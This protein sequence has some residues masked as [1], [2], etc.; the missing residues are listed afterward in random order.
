MMTKK[1]MNMTQ[2]MW[3]L[4]KKEDAATTPEQKVEIQEQINILEN[5]ECDE[6]EKR[7]ALSEFGYKKW[8]G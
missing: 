4:L 1:P 7:L 5:E 6:A 3:V 2:E 8:V